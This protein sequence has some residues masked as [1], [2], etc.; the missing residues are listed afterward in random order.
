MEKNYQKVVVE[1]FGGPEQMV[2]QVLR[3]LSPGPDQLGIKVEAA[4]VGMTDVVAVKGDYILQRNVPFTPG[5]ELVGTVAVLGSNVSG[6]S[7][8]QR[9]AVVLPKMGAYTEYCLVDAWQAVQVPGGL[10]ATEVA[11]MLLNYLTAESMLARHAK[12]L[13]TGDAVL[14]Q[15]AAGGVGDALCQLARLRELKV[16]ATASAKDIPFLEAT[17][18]VV[19]IDYTSQDFASVV[20]SREPHGAQAVFD[21]LGGKNLTKSY[22]ILAQNGVL[23]SYAFM[24]RPGHAIADTI[25][26]VLRNKLLGL[27]PGKRTAL[28]SLPNEIK[29]DHEW[30]RLSIEKMFNLLGEAKI[31]PRI[32]RTYPFVEVVAA[33][34]AQAS[35]QVSGKIVLQMS[36]TQNF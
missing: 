5:Y 7:V 22:G 14:I 21:H 4:G 8:G 1:E 11:G 9:V 23:V 17:Y 27:L 10:S 31:M 16:Y 19:G 29:K 18:G 20:A 36:Q 32:G 26:G 35:R 34:T 12:N 3:P 33:C 13:R 6:F 2:L 30:Y 28:C 25:G 24:G 15:G